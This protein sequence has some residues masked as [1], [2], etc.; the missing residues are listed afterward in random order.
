MVE[1]IV[2]VLM[3]Q[4]MNQLEILDVS[5]MPFNKN[6]VENNKVGYLKQGSLY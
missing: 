3:E 2:D 6:I 1:S 5:K 4:D